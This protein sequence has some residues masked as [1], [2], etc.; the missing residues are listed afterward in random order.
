MFATEDSRDFEDTRD[1]VVLA[2]CDSVAGETVSNMID[3]LSKEFVRK[4]EKD[5]MQAIQSF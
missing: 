3:F 1:E 5:R 2:S 4:E